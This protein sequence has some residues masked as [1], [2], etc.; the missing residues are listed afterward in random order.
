MKKTLTVAVSKQK[1]V[2][3]SIEV[4]LPAVSTY[5]RCSSSSDGSIL[6]VT[7]FGIVLR[8]PKASPGHYYLIKV[9]SNRQE[10]DDFEVESDVKNEY[11]IESQRHPLRKEAFNLL[12]SDNWKYE[13]ISEDT[14]YEERKK[15]LDL[16]I[17]WSS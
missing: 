7:L 4:D 11:F 14:F 6:W 12:T 10:F 3:E 13:K 9:T 5:Y 2:T 1:I 17:D 15:L 16:Y 8:G